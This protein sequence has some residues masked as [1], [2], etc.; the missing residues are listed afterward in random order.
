MRW[1]GFIIFILILC[2]LIF[3]IILLYGL[4]QTIGKLMDKLL[5]T[6]K[7]GQKIEKTWDAVIGRPYDFML[8][9]FT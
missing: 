4:S 2:V 8:S 7:L 9:K 6:V 3:P 1:I 5:P